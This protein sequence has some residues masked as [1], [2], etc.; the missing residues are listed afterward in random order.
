[1]QTT[2]DQRLLEF[3]RRFR[4]D[5]TPE[6]TITRLELYH[7]IEGQL[8]ER[9][10]TFEMADRDDDE[11]P[12]DLAQEIWDSCEED[13]STRP[14]GSVERYV[15][16]AFRG[17]TREPDEQK[18]F[19]CRGSC[20]TGL[21]GNSSEPPTEAGMRMA[22]M[23]QTNDL[24]GL[25]VRMAE[26]TAGSAA[27]ALERERQETQR[28]RALVL[29]GE[30]VKQ[31]MLDRSLEREL[32]RED[33]KQSQAIMMMLTQTLLQFA[34]LLLQRL[35]TPPAAPGAALPLPPSPGAPGAPTAPPSAPPPFHPPAA[36]MPAAASPIVTMRDGAIGSLL[37]TLTQEQIAQLAQ[38]LT[39]EQTNSF[40]NV[41]TSFREHPPATPQSGMKGSAAQPPGDRNHAN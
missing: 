3:I 6:G 35:L 31:Q 28:L 1:M 21:V 9:L 34:P 32:A 4:V 33:A 10:S 30:Q 37:E 25:V 12:D 17:D 19:T 13:C 29:E 7:S 20:V 5:L 24:H 22:G 14:T 41:Y 26:A 16:Q 39:P 38:V 40:L 23:R 36:P 15:I 2:P 11:D 27:V 18:A 8:G